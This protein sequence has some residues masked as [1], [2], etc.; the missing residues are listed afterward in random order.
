MGG[1]RNFWKQH[2]PGVSKACKEN[3]RKSKTA[4]AH[5]RSQPSIQAFFT[6]PPTAHVPPTI[7]TPSRVIAYA[8]DARSSGPCTMPVDLTVAPPVPNT[9]A[10]SVLAMLEKE[11]K[12]IPAL[13]KASETDKIAVFSQH[14]PIELDK[15]DA[16]K[17][18]D[19]LLNHFLGFN[20]SME[21]ISEAL[22]GGENGLAAMV[23]YLKEF[24]TW[25][26]I[27]KGL[28]EGKVSRLVHAI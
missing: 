21:S 10:I 17:Y 26:D 23:R 6:K 7:P 14:I 25:Y 5:Q 11:I 28:L 2:N 4:A 9:R 16:W 19:P 22:W 13:S 15:E 1:V 27:D 3:L 20:R 12:A 18:L 24:V 8:L